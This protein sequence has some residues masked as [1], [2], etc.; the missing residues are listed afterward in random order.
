LS[1]P[2]GV[3]DV[4][5]EHALLMGSVINVAGI[6]VNEAYAWQQ[7]QSVFTCTGDGVRKGYDL[8]SDFARFTDNTG[9]SRAIRRPVVVLGPQQWSA[10]SSWLSQ[11]FY[12]NPACRIQNDQLQFLSPPVAGD[13]VTFQY[14]R[15]TWVQD[16]DTITVFKSFCEKNGDV[17]QFDWLLMMLAIKIKWREA[18]SLDTTAVQS[19]FQDRINQL[20][21]S[22]TLAPILNL[23]G[24][25]PGSFRYLDNF[26]NTPDTNIG[27]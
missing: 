16:A 8:P 12:I 9:W 19:D 22:N 18:K 15:S 14:Q 24:G 7:M 21:Q 13:T 4:L 23:S 10:I 26:Y 6:L 11:S 25:A 17:P 20:T 27:M 1:V 2:I 5:D 3:Y